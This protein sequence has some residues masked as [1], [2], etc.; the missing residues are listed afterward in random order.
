PRAAGLTLP[1]TV[2]PDDDPGEL[3]AAVAAAAASG[4]LLLLA[5]PTALPPSPPTLRIG[6]GHAERVRALCR[7]LAVLTA[8]PPPPIPRQKGDRASAAAI[9]AAA[10]GAPLTDH[11]S[12]RLLKA[13]GVRVS[14]QAPAGSATAAA[15]VAAQI[16]YP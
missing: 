14:R 15:R 3:E 7:A 16:G 12:K 1:L 2:V 9:L 4:D 8:P 11:E 13:Y 10:S 5:A 6:L